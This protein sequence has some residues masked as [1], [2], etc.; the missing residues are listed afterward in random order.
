MTWC[1]PYATTHLPSPRR[2]RS[3]RRQGRERGRPLS[4]I[5][6]P[7]RLRRV[8]HALGADAGH[9]HHLLGGRQLDRERAGEGGTMSSGTK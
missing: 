8:R 7:H 4:G 6:R 1:C 5:R 3:P 2:T 9:G